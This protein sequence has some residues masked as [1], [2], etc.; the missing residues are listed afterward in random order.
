[1]RHLLFAAPLAVVAACSSFSVTETPSPGDAP[2]D[3][4]TALREDASAPDAGNGSNFL[5]GGRGSGIAY[6]AGHVY[7]TDAVRGIVFAADD[8]GRNA[9]RFA[10]TGGA[11]KNPL[12]TE[13]G[14][15][16]CDT[17]D[18]SRVEGPVVLFQPWDRSPAASLPLPP[19][20][21]C[22]GLAS[23]AD[24]SIVFL[25]A[26]NGSGSLVGAARR[27]GKRN[28]GVALDANPYAIASSGSTIYVTLSANGTILAFTGFD[29]STPARTDL[30]TN[31][32]DCQQ[33]AASSANVFWSR[34][35]DKRVV[36]S[37]GG[38]L[39]ASELLDERRAH[40]LVADERH[41]Y[42]R[43]EAGAIRRAQ[44]AAAAVAVPFADD[45][46][47]GF[48]AYSRTIALSGD[49]VFWLTADGVASK[50]K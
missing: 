10:E 43:N 8:D 19:D 18:L 37:P 12:A 9:T 38:F 20:H 41:V 50:A 45:A 47:T 33:I 22:L 30:A 31:Q 14:L 21:S 11:P 24:Q 26:A 46:T 3:A 28:A 1:M 25:H 35:N 34:P 27:L 39:L 36:R 23:F 48:D 17:K 6:F 40:S 44:D 4:G 49:R 32:T 2:V 5:A 16:W 13:D 29:T 15:Y 42:W 7:V